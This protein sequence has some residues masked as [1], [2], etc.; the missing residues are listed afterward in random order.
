[1]RSCGPKSQQATG[2]PQ[3]PPLTLVGILLI[4]PTGFCAVDALG[5][6]QRKTNWREWDERLNV[7]ALEPRLERT[8]NLW[9]VYADMT[10]RVSRRAGGHREGDRARARAPRGDHIK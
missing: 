2:I 7:T 9:I 6:K 10:E 8:R 4:S 5:L 3:R 1:M